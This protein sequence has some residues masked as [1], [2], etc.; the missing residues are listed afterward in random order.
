MHTVCMSI[1]KD[2]VY[3]FELIYPVE[4]ADLLDRDVVF[5][6]FVFQHTSKPAIAAG[7]ALCGNIHLHSKQVTS[8]IDFCIPVR[9]KEITHG[10]FKFILCE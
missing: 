9:F 2:S 4:A 6:M 3:C 5:A 1:I 10:F 8:N 7:L